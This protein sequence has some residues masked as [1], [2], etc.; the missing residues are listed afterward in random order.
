M[1]KL[2]LKPNISVGPFVFGTEQEE[3]WKIIK[4]KLYDFV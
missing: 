3:V 1:K 2:I 4:P